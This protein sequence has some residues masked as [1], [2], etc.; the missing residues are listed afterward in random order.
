MMSVGTQCVG[1]YT[2]LTTE[3]IQI[4]AVLPVRKT[5]RSEKRISFFGLEVRLDG[6]NPYKVL[7]CFVSISVVFSGFLL[8][9]VGVKCAILPKS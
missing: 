3:W 8:P 7:F 6:S 5:S 9:E 1:P 2:D 4:W